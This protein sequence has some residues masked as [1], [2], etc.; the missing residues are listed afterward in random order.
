MFAINKRLIRLE[1]K[2]DKALRSQGGS[3]HF[4]F[5]SVSPINTAGGRTDVDG[6]LMKL[7]D[8][9]GALEEEVRKRDEDPDPRGGRGSGW[10]GN[11]NPDGSQDVPQAG[12]SS[13]ESI[14]LDRLDVLESRATDET[15]AFGGFHFSTI[16]DVI[17]F[18]TKH[19][20]PTCAMYWD[21]MSA[22][23]CMHACMPR[24]KQAK[25]SLRESMRPKRFMHTRLWKLIWLHR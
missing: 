23:V 5:T 2:A 3:N 1:S 19:G 15:C 10:G 13:H 8:Q 21:F 17:L 20:V 6:I 4:D 24:E 14:V 7:Q 9:V 12:T 11:G 18:V 25:S 22:M 16:H